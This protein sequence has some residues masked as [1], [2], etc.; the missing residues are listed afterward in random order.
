MNRITT[1]G[2]NTFSQLID[3]E[4]LVLRNNPFQDIPAGTFRNLRNLTN[5]YLD[6]CRITELKNEWFEDLVGLRYLELFYN[7]IRSEFEV[8]S[9][10]RNLFYLRS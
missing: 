1:V 2:E 8:L 5:L 3:L 6:N 10:V 9:R 4:Y 7:E